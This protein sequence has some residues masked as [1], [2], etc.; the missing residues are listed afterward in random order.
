MPHNTPMTTE[1]KTGRAASNLLDVMEYMAHGEGALPP[2]ER[3][4]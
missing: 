2:N 1:A 3:G 4:Y